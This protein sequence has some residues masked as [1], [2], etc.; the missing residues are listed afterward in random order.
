MYKPNSLIPY[1][2]LIGVSLILRLITLGQPDL[3]DTTEGRYGAIGQEMALSGNWT[4][5]MIQIKEEL[6]PYLGK[7]PLY[8]WLSAASHLLVGINNAAPRLPSFFTAILVA[9]TTFQFAR[10]FISP[11]GA[12]LSVLILFASSFFFFLSGA[13]VV[14]VVLTATTTFGMLCTARWLRE[15]SSSGKRTWWGSL[16]FVAMALGFL[17]KG[18]VAIALMGIPLVGVLLWNRTPLKILNLPFH[19]GIPIF[20]LITAPWFYL[21]EQQNSGFINYFFINENFLRFLVKNYQDRYGLGH[22]YPYGTVW[23]AHL[24]A[25]SPWVLLL[26]LLWW[27]N[28]KAPRASSTNPNLE[29]R[30]ALLSGLAPALFFTFARQFSPLYVLPGMA[31]LAVTLAWWIEKLSSTPFEDTLRKIFAISYVVVAGIAVG[32]VVSGMVAET[33]GLDEALSLVLLLFLVAIFLRA[34]RHDAVASLWAANFSFAIVALYSAV[35]FS[36]GTLISRNRSTGPVLAAIS[37]VYSDKAIEV[38]V[39]FANFGNP[40]SVWFYDDSNNGKRFKI[41]GFDREAAPSSEVI[42]FPSR[43]L[44]NGVPSTLE[45]YKLRE[46]VGRWSWFA[47]KEN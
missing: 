23:I 34:R 10:L 4:T 35:I 33:L 19:L 36:F 22:V 25:F 24:A 11:H 15:E 13:A 12:A 41:K 30:I 31:G 2:L 5:P 3:I 6:T 40:F 42:I 38:G 47:R 18:P 17:T 27:M 8:F 44:K 46:T 7:P 43:A 28:R 32:V 20:L 9:F 1:L 45:G 39:P 37:E 26:P 16:L 29:L 21:A 14:D